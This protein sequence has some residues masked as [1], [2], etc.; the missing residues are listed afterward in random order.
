MASGTALYVAPVLAVSA[1]A[2]GLIIRLPTEM[3]TARPTASATTIVTILLIALLRLHESVVDSTEI[4]IGH[5]DFV[6]KDVRKMG[7]QGYVPILVSS[8][9]HEEEQSCKTMRSHDETSYH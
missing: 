9:L 1:S 3:P 2:G 4:A 7:T 6:V 5:P 8:R